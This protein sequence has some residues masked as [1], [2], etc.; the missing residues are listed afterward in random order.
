MMH[1]RRSRRGEARM[2][3]AR[4]REVLRL[5]AL[6]LKHTPVRPPHWQKSKPSRGGGRAWHIRAGWSVWEDRADNFEGFNA[7]CH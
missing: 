1:M 6:A 5:D 4:P 3:Q 7:R 2:C